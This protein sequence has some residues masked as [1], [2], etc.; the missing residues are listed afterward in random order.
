MNK[1]TEHERRQDLMR[2]AA[3]QVYFLQRWGSLIEGD[4]ERD[5]FQRE[6]LY[7]VSLVYREAQEPL[8]RQLTEFVTNYSRPLVF[9]KEN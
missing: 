8:V 9:G 7:L 1:I 2:L 6:V 4:R 5:D 3:F